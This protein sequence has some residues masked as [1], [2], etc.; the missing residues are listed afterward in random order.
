MNTA[1]NAHA[2]NP[3]VAR[4]GDPL[5]TSDTLVYLGL[6]LLVWGTWRVSLLGLFTAGDHIGYWLGVV[7]GVMMLALLTYPLRKYVRFAH[8]WGTMQWWFWVHMA[9]GVLGPVLILLHSTY[10]VRS[11]NAAVAFYSMIIVALSGVVGRFLY[12]RVNRGLHGAQQ[13]LKALQLKAGLDQEDVRSRLAFAPAVELQLRE[14]SQYQR[15]VCQ[16]GSRAILQLVWLPVRQNRVNR[17]CAAE[18]DRQLLRMAKE[19][20]WTAQVL[21][22]HSKRSKKAV[23]RYLDSLARVSQYSTYSRL[24]SLWHVAHVPFVYVLVLTAL[25][26][27]YAVHAY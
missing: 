18:L 20:Q 7:G 10:H 14:F 5:I 9:L 21:A 16:G 17:R 22:R 4:A 25:V 8:K 26:H 2:A 6:V 15:T 12:Q 11:L 1:V 3:E 24:F 27:I 19:R 13:D 23:A